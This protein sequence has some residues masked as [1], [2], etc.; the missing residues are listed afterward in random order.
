MTIRP[1]F[2]LAF[3]CAACAAD[4][5]EL[6]AESNQFGSVGQ[7]LAPLWT[8][9]WAVSPQSSGTTFNG[10]TLRQIVHTSIAGSAARV[11]L[12][13]VFGNQSVVIR[14]VHIAQRTSGSS[15][16]TSSDRVVTFGGQTQVTIPAG[17]L[18]ISD[19][20]AFAVSA[21]SDVAVSLFLPQAT[22]P[23]TSHGQGSQTNYIATGDVS[24]SATLSGAGTTGSYFFLMNLDVQ[25]TSSLGAVVTLGASITDGFGSSSNANRRWPNDLAVRLVNAGAVVGVL[26]QGINGNRLL[27]DSGGPSAPHRFDRDVLAQPGVQWVIFSDDP[28]NDLGSSNPPTG[29]QLI[30]EIS[31]LI[32]RAHQAGIKFLCSTL[33]PFQGAGGWTTQGETGRGQINAFVRGASSGCDGVVDQDVA[34]HDPA[35]PTR[36]LPAFDTGDHLHPNDA[37]LQAIA[38]AVNLSF[39]GVAPPAEGPFGGTPAAVPGTVQVENYDTGGQGVAYNVSTVNGTGTG[40]RTDGVDLETT[41]DTG[42]GLNIGWTSGGQWFRYTV[43]VATAGAYNVA[44]RVASATAVGSSGGSLHLQNAAGTNL[45]GTVTAPGTGGWQTWTTVNATA[46]LPAGQQV[47]TVFQDTGGYNLNSLT[48]TAASSGEA[49]FGGTPWAIPGTIQLENY[50]VGGE[51]VAYHD[52]DPVNSGGKYRTDGVDLETTTDSGGG[53]NVGWTNAGEWLKYTV[54]VASAGTRTVSFRVAAAAAVGTTAGRFHIQT[55]SGTN[56]TGTINVPGTGGWQT[57][58]NVTANITLPAG[59]QILELFVETSGFNLN[60]M[61][62]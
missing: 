2:L 19:S 17:G 20:V 60:A 54:N 3:V 38:N 55:P 8:G 18:A 52:N 5:A 56:L 48:F 40:Y 14:D 45:T 35:N 12:S 57:Y 15:I 26:N 59:Q 25:N 53:F 4:P 28:I 21:L 7:A 50:D 36:F 44:F 46:T 30:T 24:G 1:A 31:G 42:G 13:N 47:L 51:G 29:A 34:T 58:T 39:F 37:G 11:Q 41:S 9:T 22:G 61:T 32:T 6:P 49:P 62:F 16:N 27:A 10:Q 43:N 33:T 23:A